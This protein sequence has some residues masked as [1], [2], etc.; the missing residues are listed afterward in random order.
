[1]ARISALITIVLIGGSLAIVVFMQNSSACGPTRGAFN[2]I[3]VGM[4]SKQVLEILGQKPTMTKVR[5]SEK[6]CFWQGLNQA[7]LEVSFQ[8]DLVVDKAWTSSEEG[9][10]GMFLRSIFP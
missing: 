6:T 8:D 1:M 2:R 5:M 7:T 10:I 9:V 3:R 4:T